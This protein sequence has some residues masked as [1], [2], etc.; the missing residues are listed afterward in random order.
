M[1]EITIAKALKQKN[2][3]IKEISEEFR[4]ARQNNSVFA[5]AN[6]DY[7]VKY[8]LDRA[9][10]KQEEL[11]TLKQ[12][13]HEAN[14]PVRNK[15][16]RL[17]ELKNRIN[18]LRSIPSQSHNVSFDGV[19]IDYSV[20]LSQKQIDEKIKE[21]EEEIENIQEELDNFNHTTYI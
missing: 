15:I 4:K 16:F 2:K 10:E 19:K 7:E 6:K 12:K 5:N 1:E 11:I 21:T 13:I 20:E 3:L 8:C 14:A 17:S 18:E 9:Y